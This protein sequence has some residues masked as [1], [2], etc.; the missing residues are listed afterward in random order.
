[1]VQAR[2]VIT[3]RRRPGSRQVLSESG[4]LAAVVVEQLSEALE[5]VEDDQIG[6]EL[7][8]TDGM[9]DDLRATLAERLSQQR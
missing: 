5:L 4:A 6:L 7:V 8:E 1:M 9:P 2:G 3:Q